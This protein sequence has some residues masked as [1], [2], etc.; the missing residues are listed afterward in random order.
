M[1]GEAKTCNLNVFAPQ[2]YLW[3]AQSKLI[4][5]LEKVSFEKKS[6]W[7]GVA[8]KMGKFSGLKKI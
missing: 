6:A 4:P 2:I 5:N 7:P 3:K 8:V 1:A